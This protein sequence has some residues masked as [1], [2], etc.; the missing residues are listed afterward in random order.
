[1]VFNCKETERT[2]LKVNDTVL[3]EVENSKFL[4]L[5]VDHK[6]IWEDHL[7][8]MIKKIRSGIYALKLSS[9]YMGPHEKLMIYYALVYSHLQYG[10]SIWG[11]MIKKCYLNRLCILQ[12][13]CI[14]LIF[15]LEPRTNTSEI[16]Q[17]N[18][19]L[20]I[21]Q[22]IKLEQ[23]KFMFR[24]QNGHISDRIQNKFNQL[25][26]VRHNYNTRHRNDPNIPIHKS[27]KY[28]DSIL[29]QGPSTWM[30]LDNSIKDC[31]NVKQFSKK[32]KLHLISV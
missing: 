1:M 8:N 29:V 31:K 24:I 16:M 23:Q 19:I 7:T 6:L 18:K 28:A 32:Y 22:I 20:S 2:I 10:I 17:K 11:S 3:K 15:N 9:K 12:N 25:T 27:K 14:R 13:T 26:E 30:Y 4:G 5:T 21:S